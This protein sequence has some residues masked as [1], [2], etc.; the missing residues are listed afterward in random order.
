MRL[1][2]LSVFHAEVDQPAI[3]AAVFEIPEATNRRAP[4]AD[5][6]R[7]SQPG[8]F[9]RHYRPRP[10]RTRG[11][12]DRTLAKAEAERPMTRHNAVALLSRPVAGEVGLAAFTAEQP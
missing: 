11:T 10:Y 2:L 7:Q 8:G 5:D 9:R 3:V 6:A 12:R 1:V 4:S